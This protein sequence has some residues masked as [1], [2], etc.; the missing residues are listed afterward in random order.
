MILAPDLDSRATRVTLERAMSAPPQA[1]YRAWTQ[2]FDRWFA[3]PGTVLM[4][5]RVDAPFFFE[6]RFQGERHAHYGRFLALEPDRLV[7]MT[8]VTAAG[9]RGVETVVT[10]QLS[11]HG[12]GTTLKLEHAGFPDEE[13]RRRHDAAWPQ[14]L[15]QLDEVVS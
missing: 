1:L 9:T 5:A 10:V 2:G 8:W 7:Q 6:T 11:P 4:S 12:S 3:A 14:V 13:S 15:Q